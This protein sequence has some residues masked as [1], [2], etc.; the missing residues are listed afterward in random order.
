MSIP[1]HHIHCIRII[2]AFR[3]YE[4]ETELEICRWQSTYAQLGPRHRALLGS[5]PAKFA[6]ARRAART[7]RQF[8]D[9]MLAAFDEDNEESQAPGHLAGAGPEAER[10]AAGSAWCP[11]GDAE[12]VG[13]GA[14]GAAG[15]SLGATPQQLQGLRSVLAGSKQ[16]GA[17]RR[18]GRRGERV[19]A[20]YREAESVPLDLIGGRLTSVRTHSSRCSSL[21]VSSQEAVGVAGHLSWHKRNQPRSYVG[22]PHLN[23]HLHAPSC[24]TRRRAHRCS[25]AGSCAHA[26]TVAQVAAMAP[27]TCVPVPFGHCH[28][29]LIYTITLSRLLLAPTWLPHLRPC[30]LLHR[31]AKVRYVL[32]NL[33]RDWSSE[34]AAERAQSYGRICQELDRLFPDR[35]AP[36]GIWG[37]KQG[38][39]RRSWS[40][41]FIALC[42]M[43]PRIASAAWRASRQWVAC[44]DLSP[45]EAGGQLVCWCT[46]GC[47]HKQNRGLCTLPPLNHSPALC[48]LPRSCPWLAVS[49]NQ[50]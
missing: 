24:R 9:A 13:R 27:S 36:V 11:P 38:L 14:M 31:V 30:H 42:T 17:R 2:F 15:G 21:E 6:V 45:G 33:A 46:R 4:A 1:L 48:L 50:Q 26:H 37:P 41:M 43:E 18:W 44:W 7:N 28:G 10:I 3:S 22:L 20:V 47:K 34:G 23:M 39:Q 29:F 5:L 16:R 40:V 8:V 32:K 25:Q 49:T 19:L 12:K 35:C